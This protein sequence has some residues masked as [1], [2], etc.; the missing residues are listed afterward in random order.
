M[1]CLLA[2]PS[3]QLS[4]SVGSGW[5]RNALRHHWL[6]PVSCYFRDCKAAGHESDSFK[7]RF[8]L[9]LLDDGL[10]QEISVRV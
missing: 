4:V 10:A 7:W 6:M 3:V 2:A 8:A 9:S 1:V 5:P